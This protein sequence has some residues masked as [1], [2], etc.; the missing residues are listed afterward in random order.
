MVRKICFFA[1]KE[2]KK[3]SFP[4]GTGGTTIDLGDYKVSFLVLSGYCCFCHKQPLPNLCLWRIPYQRT[5]T[6]DGFPKRNFPGSDRISAGFCQRV[7]NGNQSFKRVVRWRTYLTVTRQVFRN[8]HQVLIKWIFVTLILSSA[9]V[10][11]SLITYACFKNQLRFV[12]CLLCSSPFQLSLFTKEYLKQL[13]SC[14]GSLSRLAY[15]IKI[16]LLIMSQN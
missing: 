16:I 7:D 1:N 15:I 6:T 4:R 12:H 2:S 3:R 13:I 10:L 8:R 14:V 9:F 5:A 11:T